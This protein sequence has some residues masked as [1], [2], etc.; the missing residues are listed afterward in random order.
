MS[1]RA[2][3]KSKVSRP[4]R[5]IAAVRRALEAAGDR[6]ASLA[7]EGGP[8]R[9]WTDR[10]ATAALAAAVV[11]AAALMLPR[12]IE[13]SDATGPRRLSRELPASAS[14]PQVRFAEEP[15]WLS[16]TERQ[17]IEISIAAELAGASPFDQAALARAAAAATATGWFPHEARLRRTGVRE[18]VLETPLRRPRAVVRQGGRDHLVDLQGVR[19]P[20]DWP[21]GR[22]PGRLPAFVGVADPPPALPGEPWRGG[23]VP[24][25]FEVL[26]ALVSRA[27]SGEI[28]AIDVASVSRGGP[29]LLLTANG[30]VI[31]WGS[32]TPGS[33]S[34]VPVA[35]RLAYLDRLHDRLGSIEPPPGK[36]WD[37]R[38]DYLASRPQSSG[39]DGMLA[40]SGSRGP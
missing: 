28:A 8:L 39:P 22:A 40:A 14:G 2:A 7:P 13:R 31:V 34:E 26:D 4:S 38:L 21:A 37:L 15:E 17:R 24:L 23:T 10:V 29:V 18:V 30:G 9:R 35:T 6:L 27:W 20:M 36:A 3:S 33:A 11:A 12:L 25:A 32:P 5:L 16:D 19:L 1:R